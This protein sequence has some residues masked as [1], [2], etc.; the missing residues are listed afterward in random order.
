MWRAMGGA[1]LTAIAAVLFIAGCSGTTGET[2]GPAEPG[3]AGNYALEVPFVA[4]Q[5][6]IADPEGGDFDLRMVA[7]QG[8]LALA[9]DSSYEHRIVFETYIDDR[10][11]AR[12]NWMDRGE[13][14][15]SAEDLELHR[16]H[17]RI[18]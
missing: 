9:A 11:D 3:V 4:F 7:T 2:S 15:A 16:V 6:R 18:G 12:P 14:Y 17:R 10:L 5:G 1:G 13:V 8:T